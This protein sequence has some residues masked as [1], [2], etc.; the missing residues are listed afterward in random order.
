MKKL[1]GLLVAAFTL[2][3]PSLAFAQGADQMSGLTKM[4]WGADACDD[5]M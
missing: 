5:W 1:P 4:N 2:L 3:L